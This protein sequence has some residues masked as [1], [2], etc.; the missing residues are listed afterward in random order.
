MVLPSPDAHASTRARYEVH[1]HDAACASCH[2]LMDPLDFA[3]ESYDAIGRFRTEEADAPIDARG[4][5]TGTHEPDVEV[6]GAD[7]LARTLAASPDV[8]RCFTQQMWRFAFRRLA[9]ETD[10]CSIEE[11]DAA[12]VRTGGDVRALMIAIV[13]SDAFLHR[14]ETP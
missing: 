5:V 13:R 8:S 6:D 1:T 10:A 14:M 3:L 9:V 4:V 7:A 11:A 12:M 2:T